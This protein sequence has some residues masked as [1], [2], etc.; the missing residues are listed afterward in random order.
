[1]KKLDEIGISP[2][3][4]RKDAIMTIKALLAYSAMVERCEAKKKEL[5]DGK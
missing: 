5:D 4:A 2:A 3:P 1:M